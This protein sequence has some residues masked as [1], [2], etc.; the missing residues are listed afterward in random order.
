MAAGLKINNYQFREDVIMPC[1]IKI[2]MKKRGC[3]KIGDGAYNVLLWPEINGILAAR[4]N[5]RF[6]VTLASPLTKQMTIWA[7]QHSQPVSCGPENAHQY[8]WFVARGEWLRG[9]GAPPMLSVALFVMKRNL[10][11]T[12]HKTLPQALLLTFFIAKNIWLPAS[13][14]KYW[15]CSLLSVEAEK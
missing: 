5:I 1:A 13:G 10:V 4:E 11:L 3:N 14:L 8:L 6:Q 15:G 2:T 12:N 9:R 7:N